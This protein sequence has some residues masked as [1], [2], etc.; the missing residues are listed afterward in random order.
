MSIKHYIPLA[1]VVLA[2]ATAITLIQRRHINT[3]P[4]PQTLLAA[5]ADVQHEITRVP[6]HFDHISDADE[7]AVGDMMAQHLTASLK[8]NQ[9]DPSRDDRIEA[10]LQEVGTRT[11]AHTRRKL[12][13]R[14]HYIPDSNF[15]NAFALPG[16]HI[17]VG[18]GLLSLMQSEDALAA[19]LG[20]EIEHVD[21]RHCAERVQTQAELHQ[22]GALGQIVGLPIDLF[23]TGYS[24]DQEL[25]ADRDGTTLAV[26][27]GYSYTGILQ[28]FDEFNRRAAKDNRTTTKAAGPIG[29]AAQLSLATLSGYF[30]SHPPSAQ[31]SIQIRKMAKDLNW[32]TQPLKALH[33]SNS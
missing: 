32:P 17:F 20:H 24:K 25:E 11:A 7:I 1:I 8:R 9:S 13:W 6:A 15:V 33:A 21:L 26:Q 18:Q 14:F 27:A 4:S 5:A 19:V 31:R 16:G 12:P 23:I 3:P 30:A 2:G 10:Y 28:L 29:E 22:L